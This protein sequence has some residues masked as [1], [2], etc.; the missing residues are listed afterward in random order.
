FMSVVTSIR[1]DPQSRIWVQRRG[2]DG[3]AA[4]PIDL[5]MP[6]GRYIGTLPPQ[7]LPGAVSASSL[8][9]WVVTDAE[10]GVERVVVRRLP[11][12]WQ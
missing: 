12:S 5:M 3:K 1:T 11:A 9:A 7:E 2:A 10:L 8:A 4:G 6:D